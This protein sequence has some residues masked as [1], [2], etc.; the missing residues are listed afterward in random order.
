MVVC[1]LG[2]CGGDTGKKRGLTNVGKSDKTDLG[3]HTQFESYSPFLTL[4]AALCKSRD[5]SSGGCEMAVAPAASAALTE[6]EFVGV[7][8]IVDDTAG[9]LLTDDSFGGDEDGNVLTVCAVHFSGHTVTAGLG[10]KL[11]L[12]TK[13][14]KSV[15]AG[16][17]LE[18]Y[19][20][21]ST[22]VTAVGTA[23]RNVFLT[24][25]GDGAVSAVTCLYVNFYIIYK[26]L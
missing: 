17:D 18:D 16:I 22:A 2:L 8:H 9:I 7:C 12:I 25:E 3:K 26:H 14:K 15:C 20:T 13:G 1:D 21:A 23:R 6:D 5:L 10:N 4:C 24:V 11:S 19:V